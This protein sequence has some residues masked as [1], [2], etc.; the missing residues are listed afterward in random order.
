MTYHDVA[1]NGAFNRNTPMETWEI[2]ALDLLQAKDCYSTYFSFGGDFKDH[3]LKTNSVKGYE[4]VYDAEY[5]PFDIDCEDNL[6]EAQK[7]AILLVNRLQVVYD[8]CNADTEVYFTG[9]KGFHI[10]IPVK[11]FG[12][13]TPSKDLAKLFKKT[14]MEIAAGL[15]IDTSIY[16]MMRLWRL[17]NTVNSKTGLYKISLSVQELYELPIDQIKDLAKA[18]RGIVPADPTFRQKL[19]EVYKKSFSTTPVAKAKVDK[20]TLYPKGEKRCIYN[21]LNNGVPEGERNNA[22]IRLAVYFKGRFTQSTVTALLKSWSV[23]HA[24]S[25]PDDEINRTIASAMNEYDFGCNDGLLVKYC[26]KECSYHLKKKDVIEDVKDIKEIEASYKNYIEHIDD[27]KVDLSKWLPQFS[28]ASRGVTAGEV[29]VTIAGSGVGKTAFL[30][31]MIWK[32]GLPTMFFSYELPD[33]LTF[34]RFYQIVNG[35][36]GEK[37]EELYKKGHQNTDEIN[38]KFKDIFFNFNSSIKIDDVPNIVA[39]AEEKKKTKIRLV[40]IDYLGLVKGGSGSRYEKVSYIAEALKDVAKKTNTVVVCLAQ[41]SRNQ[42]ALGDEN[43]N[44]TSGKDSGSIEN[45]GDLVIGMS[46]PHKN[47]T[48]AEDNVIRLA[49]LKNRKGRD[50]NFIDCY[51]DKSNLRITE[52]GV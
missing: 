5:L 28:R 38:Y 2:E 49:I 30:Q 11:V 7:Q 18:P 33:I 37:V 8:L 50:G 44:L 39:L 13:V 42:G 51:F 15:E 41:V 3:V 6:A 35:V 17:P 47:S 32:L 16:D 21:I 27:L 1:I 10:Q 34:E 25:L 46:R 40:A 22:L 23:D 29:I 20:V 45:T 36:T 12:G 48:D 43:L 14:A 24:L 9:A 26:S 52:M 19:M 31:N 4:G